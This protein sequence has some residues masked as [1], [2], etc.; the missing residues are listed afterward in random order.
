MRAGSSPS[1]GCTHRMPASARS[2][3][4]EHLWRAPTVIGRLRDRL[5]QDAVGRRTGVGE[6]LLEAGGDRRGC[7]SSAIRRDALARRMPRQSSTAL[8][9]PREQIGEARGQSIIWNDLAGSSAGG[10]RA[11]DL[12]LS[13]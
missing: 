9:A 11:G 13:C 10:H 3:R 7:A 8:C 12:G 1:C 4:V 5:D 2:E 6:R